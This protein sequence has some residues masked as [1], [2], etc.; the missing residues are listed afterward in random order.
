MRH[1]MQCE[2]IIVT[3][4][5]IIVCAVEALSSC[6]NNPFERAEACQPLAL[7]VCPCVHVRLPLERHE[8]EIGAWSMHS[9]GIEYA[10]M[11]DRHNPQ[12]SSIEDAISF[13]SGSVCNTIIVPFIAHC[14]RMF[15]V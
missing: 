13:A 3:N 5:S 4:G 10:V 15:N 1:C 12:S 9:P 7:F 11:G 14:V 6:T 2:Q 8:T